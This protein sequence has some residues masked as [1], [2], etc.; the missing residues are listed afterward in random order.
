MNV[1]CG[2]Q[3]EELRTIDR[4]VCGCQLIYNTRRPTK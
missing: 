2:K 4:F 3:W 1:P